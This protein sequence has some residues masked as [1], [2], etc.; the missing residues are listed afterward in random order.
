MLTQ[1]AANQY[2]WFP[3]E[4]GS[5][6]LKKPAAG[7]NCILNAATATEINGY[8]PFRTLSHVVSSS[9][10]CVEVAEFCDLFDENH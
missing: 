1:T 4:D 3:Q 2:Y 5:F 6:K 10:I 7:D 8:H 9:M